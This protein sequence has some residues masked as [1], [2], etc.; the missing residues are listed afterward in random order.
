MWSHVTPLYEGDE[1]G[2][3]NETITY[4]PSAGTVVDYTATL[5][6][7]STVFT[8]TPSASGVV[9]ATVGADLVGLYFI[10][11]IEYQDDAGSIIE[12]ADFD[13][14]PSGSVMVS[15]TPDPDNIT[16]YD[17]NCVC[18]W[19]TDAVPPVPMVAT[20]DLKVL[21]YQNYDANQALLKGKIG[22]EPT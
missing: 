22:E 4:A 2:V 20:L 21:I 5:T 7:S 13:D 1:L 17:I 18:N 16:E 19:L 15:F 10:E 12:V 11:S 8:V 3:I 14:V 6:P 9:C